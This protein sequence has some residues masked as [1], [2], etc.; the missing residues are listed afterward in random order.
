MKPDEIFPPGNAAAFLVC[1]S[2]NVET[3]R[4]IRYEN[5]RRFR[6]Y[7]ETKNAIVLNVIQR[8]PVSIAIVA[9]SVFYRVMKIFPLDAINRCTF[10]SLF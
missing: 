8:A 10:F 4:G 9:R 2:E 3:E 5:R 7:L 6:R 1:L